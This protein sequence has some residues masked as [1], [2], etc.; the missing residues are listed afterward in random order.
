MIPRWVISNHLR[1]LALRKEKKSQ[2]SHALL[3]AWALGSPRVPHE[4]SS[5]SAPS[6][7]E[8]PLAP[9]ALT[10]EQSCRLFR[11]LASLRQNLCSQH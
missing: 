8:R 2:I 9:W 11:A 5:H 7:S 10:H 4:V 6:P 1:S 3:L